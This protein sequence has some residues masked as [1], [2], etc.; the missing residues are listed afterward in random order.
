MQI[1]TIVVPSY[2]MEKYIRKN[3]ESFIDIRIIDD[4][5]V[6]IVNDGSKDD[7][8]SIAQEFVKKFPN[9]FHLLNKEN[10][11]HGSAVNCG[12]KNASGKYFKIVDADD[13]L[14]TESLVKL[15]KKLKST[16]VDLFLTNYETVDMFTHETVIYKFQN[17]T[18]GKVYSVEDAI[19]SGNLF[20]MHSLCYKTA[21]LQ[22][23]EISLQEKIYYV[24]E[25]FNVLP[26]VYVKSIYFYDIILYNYMIGNCNQSISVEN[27][28][29]RIDHKIKIIKRLI[30]YIDNESFVVINKEYCYQ[31]IAGM[32]T[33]VYLVML[34][35]N[36]DKSYGRNYTK[37]FRKFIKS[38]NI[39]LE[40]MS[41]FKY[42][43]FRLMSFF[44]VSQ[45]K[46]DMIFG[47]VKKL[48]RRHCCLIL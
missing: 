10:G 25:E 3:L 17:I 20:P 5:E 32:I 22:E 26:F 1:L 18:Y 23:N 16:D 11:G 42:R 39:K 41:K 46:Y 9:T 4:I 34:I 14:D 19:K 38:K 37:L 33:S 45:K 15:V 44:G 12:I 43:I 13:W 7:T 48:M 36:E 35:Y 28:I 8:E 30:D 29:K 21:I 6:L 27:Q 31:K 40:Q 24:D 47:A 2:N